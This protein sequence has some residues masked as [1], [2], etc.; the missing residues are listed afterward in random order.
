MADS[1]VYF[2]ANEELP[3]LLKAG[4]AV[5]G[6]FEYSWHPSCADISFKNIEKP[7]LQKT[8]VVIIFAQS[9]TEQ[10]LKHNRDILLEDE[11]NYLFATLIIGDASQF[12]WVQGNL[13]EYDDF[14][15]PNFTEQELVFKIQHLIERGNLFKKLMRDLHEASDIALLSMSQSS[16]LGEISRFILSSYNCKNYEELL[17]AL[18]ET[19]KVFS[20]NCSA[21]VVVDDMVT[22]RL[23]DNAPENVREILLRHHNLK[24]I[25]HLGKD[26]IISFAHA[27][28][29]VHDM[30]ID[31]EHQFGRLLDNITVLG[32]CFEARVKGIHAEEEAQEASRAKTM[33]LATMSHELR[34]PMNSVIG[35]T[36]RLMKKL[37]GRIN[38]KEQRHLDAIKRNGDHLLSLINDILDMSKI[39]V[40]LMEIH[41]EEANPVELVKNIYVQLQP[42]AQNNNLE[43]TLDVG[44]GVPEIQADPKRFTQ[45]IMNLTSNAIKYTEQGSVKMRIE[46]TKDNQ[47]GEGVKVTISDTGIGISDEDKTLLFGNFVQIDSALSRKIEGTGLGLAISMVFANMHG[48]RIDV[49]SAVGVGSDFS[50]LLPVAMQENA[51]KQALTMQQSRH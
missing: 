18:F 11:Y 45:I 4:D 20:V 25:H 36:E 7:L 21:L 39:E 14:L 22:L 29:M 12:D 38:T 33:F 15:F 40:G 48:G 31:K 28:M 32:N 8:R 19:I 44:E 35:F 1:E 3:A 47:I 37:E 51:N 26:V 23:A 24:R 43:F 41:P 42:I 27:S 5:E 50:L 9:M 30:P 13:K 34:T 17:D 49:N 6:H 2:I 10:E 46:C 16:E